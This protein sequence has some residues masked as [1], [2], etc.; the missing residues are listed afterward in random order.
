MHIEFI[1]LLRCPRP[2]EETWLVAAFYRMT[3]RVVLEGKLGC[4]ICGAEYAIRDGIAFFRER[5]GEAS[6]VDGGDI[7]AP[8]AATRIAAFLDLARPGALAVL[9]GSWA[10]A[11]DAVASLTSARVIALNS[12][13]PT[14]NEGVLQVESDLP[15]PLAS[16]SLDGIALDSKWSTNEMLEE[17]ARALR[18]RGRLLAS[19]RLE[20]SGKFGELARDADYVVAE[21][22][23]DLVSLRR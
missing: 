13:S 1:D 22:I 4:H 8:D 5:G 19:S 12:A 18:P 6:V 23:G 17:A 7:E 21:Y 10:N 2:H 15:L 20:L 3:G 11:S 14:S 9:T 16:H